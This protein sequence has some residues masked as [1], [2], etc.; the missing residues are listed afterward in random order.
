MDFG[1]QHELMRLGE[2]RDEI[3]KIG[4]DLGAVSTFPL[5]DPSKADQKNEWRKLRNYLHLQFFSVVILEIET[6]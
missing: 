2:F 6:V 5:H 4:S 3:H 1:P